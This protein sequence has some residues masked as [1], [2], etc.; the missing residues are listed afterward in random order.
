M[1][2]NFEVRIKFF[3]LLKVKLNL[4]RWSLPIHKQ[5]LLSTDPIT[6]FEPEYLKIVSKLPI[7]YLF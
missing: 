7:H 6:D 5:R 2:N 4:I 3:S 1:L